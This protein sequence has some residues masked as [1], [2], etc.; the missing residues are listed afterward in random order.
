MGEISISLL[1]YIFSMKK[2][3]TLIKLL[4]L[5]EINICRKSAYPKS[6][7]SKVSHLCGE[8]ECEHCIFNSNDTEFTNEFKPILLDVL[9]E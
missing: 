4:E 9:A 1:F 3:K 8:I 6:V 7:P 5:D 2:L